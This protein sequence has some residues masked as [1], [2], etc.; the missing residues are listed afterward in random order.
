MDRKHPRITWADWLGRI[1]PR[2]VL[3]KLTPQP[4]LRFVLTVF[5][6]WAA[7]TRWTRF[8]RF[9]VS[10][11]T[12]DGSQKTRVLPFHISIHPTADTCTPCRIHR[13]GPRM[14]YRASVA[15]TPRRSPLVEFGAR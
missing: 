12:A 11:K 7:G 15:V 5:S 4:I 9:G 3:D 1:Q 14:A 8:C 2:L 6:A 13:S 10:R